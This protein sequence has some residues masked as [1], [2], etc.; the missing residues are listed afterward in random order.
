MKVR[1]FH[2]RGRRRSD[3][4]QPK[5]Q[6]QP[7]Y[8]VRVLRH[9]LRSTGTKVF[10]KDGARLFSMTIFEEYLVEV[11]DHYTA[12]RI[13]F[14]TESLAALTQHLIDLI[15]CTP[16]TI[17]SWVITL[18]VQMRGSS[19]LMIFIAGRFQLQLLHE[20]LRRV[21]DRRIYPFFPSLLLHQTDICSHNQICP[22][23]FSRCL[24]AQR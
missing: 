15:P 3:G 17:I 23:S 13:C 24:S 14:L 4:C 12:K 11:R 16:C 22:L 7:G 6:P 18:N 20:R 2:N 19:S 9:I 5:C 8:E 21:S 1:R 10:N